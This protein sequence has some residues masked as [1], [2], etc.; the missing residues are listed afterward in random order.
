M[1]LRD[2][3]E[4]KWRI[5]AF[6]IGLTLLLVL[7]DYMNPFVDFYKTW[8][9]HYVFNHLSWFMIFLIPIF[10]TLGIISEWE[11]TSESEHWSG[12]FF[13][14]VLI[15]VYYY[16][17]KGFLFIGMIVL[18][19]GLPNVIGAWYGGY[20]L[21][22]RDFSLIYFASL[23]LSMLFVWRFTFAF[24]VLGYITSHIFGRSIRNFARS[25]LAWISGKTGHGP[26]KELVV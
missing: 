13:S 26:N 4:K 24:L 18:D 22:W 17:I 19:P 5:V 25:I 3:V 2:V 1:G 16:I 9:M 20:I 15:P 7:L 23:P 14:C 10:F 11:V 21:D 6:T 12:L 8:N